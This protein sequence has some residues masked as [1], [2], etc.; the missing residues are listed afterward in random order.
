MISTLTHLKR[1][2]S[3]PC[4]AVSLYVLSGFIDVARF[5]RI[6]RLLLYDLSLALYGRT[7]PLS[8]DL[9]FLLFQS[10][11]L[12]ISLSCLFC[13]LPCLSIYLYLSL[14][15]CVSIQLSTSV[16]RSALLF[17]LFYLY[18]SLPF[19]SLCVS[20]SNCSSPLSCY[21]FLSAYLSFLSLSLFPFLLFF[22][23]SFRLNIGV[24]V[25]R[26]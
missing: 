4:L 20:V 18:L 8:S 10:F 17:C 1:F 12:S 23:L 19:L 13:F 26:R 16:C 9:A 15:L 5:T 21:L 2:F 25:N 7:S 11:F 22:S 3:F 6:S 24:D 14:Y